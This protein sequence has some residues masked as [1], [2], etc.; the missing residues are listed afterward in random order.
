MLILLDCRSLLFHPPNGEKARFIISCLDIIARQGDFEWLF[1]VDHTYREGSLTGLP[2]GR[3]LTRKDF[4]GKTGWKI[5]YDWQIPRVVKKYRPDLLMTTGGLTARVGIPQCVWMPE[6]PDTALRM[7]DRKLAALYR[8]RFSRSLETAS[9]LFTFS[10]KDASFLAGSLKV[11]DPA[12]GK[13]FKDKIVVLQGAPGARYQPLPE[14]ERQKIREV[15]TGG[16][17]YFLALAGEGEKEWV[18]LLKAFSRFKKRQQ[19]NMQIVLL[20]SAPGDGI[21]IGGKLETYKYRTDVHRVNDL[22]GEERARIFAGCYAF[23]A[24][25]TPESLGLAQLDAWK[26]GV[27]VIAPDNGA[28]AG[29]AFEAALYAPPEDE[30]SLAAHLMRVYKDER[31]RATLVEKGQLLVQ[32]LSWERTAGQVREGMERALGGFPKSAINK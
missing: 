13:V 14:E 3:I 1:L 12:A 10:E 31:L 2:P 23:I 29:L 15:Y 32:P 24:P 22:S 4:P 9:A 26:A 18:H 20:S 7:D 17:E 27:P 21:R 5:W 8:A 11:E 16:M 6:R 28:G 30:E 25:F 19:S